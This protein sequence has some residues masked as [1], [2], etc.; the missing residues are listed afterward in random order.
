MLPYLAVW[1]WCGCLLD[2]GAKVESTNAYRST[3]LRQAAWNG[4]LDMCRLLL[5]WKAKVDRLD[6]WKE[7]PLNLA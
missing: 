3:A 6:E 4:H 1:S 2:V 5:D 7:T